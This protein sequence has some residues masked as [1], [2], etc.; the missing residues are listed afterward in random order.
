MPSSISLRDDRPVVPLRDDRPEHIHMVVCGVAFFLLYAVLRAFH[1]SHMLASLLI[2]VAALPLMYAVV[3]ISTW[4]YFRVSKPQ[5]RRS[6]VHVTDAGCSTLI[7]V[8]FVLLAFGAIEKKA[9]QK[10]SR[11][12]THRSR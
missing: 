12:S 1:C 5:T 6:T 9:Y 11:A 7:F 3:P 10:T 4:I 2:L 8:A